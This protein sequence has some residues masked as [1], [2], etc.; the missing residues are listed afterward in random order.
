MKVYSI[1]KWAFYGICV[2]ILALPVSRHWK[3]LIGGE[4]APGT[5]TGFTRYN[6]ENRFGKVE[7]IFASEVQFRAGDSIY[8]AHGPDDFQLERGR[9]LRVIYDPD[10]PTH[11]C[12]IAFSGF[13]LNNYAALPIILLVLWASFYLSFNSYMNKKRASRTADLAE[14]PYRPFRSSRDADSLSR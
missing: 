3:L 7:R 11:N 5:V 12:L 10:D 14:T 1:N 13:Y 4:G 2:L 8:T 6:H 9:T